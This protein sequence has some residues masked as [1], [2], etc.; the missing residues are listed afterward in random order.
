[1]LY[2]YNQHGL[3][4][5]FFYNEHVSYIKQGLEIKVPYGGKENSFSRF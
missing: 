2:E 3:G 5:D 1:M 4:S